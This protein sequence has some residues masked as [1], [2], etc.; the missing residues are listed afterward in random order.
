VTITAC[1]NGALYST[2]ALQRLLDDPT[3]DCI[4]WAF[5]QTAT[6]RLYPHMYAWLD[7]DA[8]MRLRDVS[9]K[10]PFTDRPNVYAIIGTMFF[11]R[12]G[13]FRWG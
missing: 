9:I 6:S 2:D 5:K 1:D 4:V 12:A 3:I 7:V 11:R 10:A 13:D 8:S